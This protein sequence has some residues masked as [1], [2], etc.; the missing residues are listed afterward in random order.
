M[1]T[2]E[3]IWQTAQ[4]IWENTPNI[5]WRELADKLATLFDGMETPS[6]S[7]IN[8]RA[9]K[10]NWQKTTIPKG[11]NKRNKHAT[12]ATSSETNS[13]QSLENNKEDENATSLIVATEE[14][15]QKIYAELENLVLTA[16]E[17][18]A[19]ISK[20]RKRLRHLGELLE[21]TVDT[22]DILHSL[23]AKTDGEKIQRVIV[24]S[25]TL[26]RTLNQLTNSQKVIAE[27][28]FVVCGITV[29]DFKESEHDKRQASLNALAG[30]NES[31]SMQREKTQLEMLERLSRFEK[32]AES[33]NF[34]ELVEDNE[35]VII[36]DTGDL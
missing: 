7:S 25:E 36:E 14:T 21:N 29:D 18:K 12:G 9:K 27:Q 33:G 20:H 28:E 11:G 16:Q 6:Y 26:S 10:Y 22:I 19:I 32:I 2:P 5:T 35:D 17:K 24:V 30:L 4:T 15:E 31:A 34:D 3:E 8:R 23:D 1:A 13:P